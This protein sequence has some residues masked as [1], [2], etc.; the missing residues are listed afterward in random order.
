MGGQFRHHS[1]DTAVLVA[2][3][4]LELFASPVEPLQMSGFS[5]QKKRLHPKEDKLSLTSF[6]NG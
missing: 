5:R 3:I 1:T 4:V 6:F 2:F